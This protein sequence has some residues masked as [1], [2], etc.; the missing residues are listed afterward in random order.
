MNEIDISDIST[1]DELFEVIKRQVIAEYR[2]PNL[3]GFS[4][5]PGRSSVTDVRFIKFALSN[6]VFRVL[7]GPN[8]I[9]PTSL[10]RAKEY[11]CQPSPPT[12]VPIPHNFLFTVSQSHISTHQ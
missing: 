2:R 3:F 10:V 5:L 4:W 1:D 8:S 7:D 11:D 9:A 6:G 12:E